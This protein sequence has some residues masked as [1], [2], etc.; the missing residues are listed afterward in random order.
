MK[1]VWNIGL[2]AFLLFVFHPSYAD[3]RSTSLPPLE[4][5][6]LPYINLEGVL[7]AY[8]PLAQYLETHLD[9]PVRLVSARDYP[10]LLELTAKRAYPVLITASHFARLAEVESG[11][12]PILR[13][14]TTFHEIL[15]IRTESQSA[16]IQDLRGRIVI[17]PDKLAQ[18]SMRARELFLSHGLDPDRDL[19]IQVANG[20]KN[21]VYS[22]LNGL[23]DAAVVSEGGY[24][25]MDADIK[26][27][28]KELRPDEAY[29]QQRLEMIPVVYLVSSDISQAER[30]RLSMLI[31]R[32]ANENPV[33]KTWINQLKYEGLR[34]VT[35]EEM[36]AMDPQVTELRKIL[37]QRNR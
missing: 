3:E 28:L 18:V 30:Q 1:A 32:F 5:G 16:R 20:H 36:A 29:Q 8:G 6:V 12:V 13:R 26:A 25:H 27:S 14:L 23:A 37:G 19:T 4:V 2:L 7:K 22:V 11:Y 33:G 15:L 10:H 35:A 24:R 34:P 21:A 9:R 17:V 31:A